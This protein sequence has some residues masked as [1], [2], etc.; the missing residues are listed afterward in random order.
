MVQFVFAPFRLLCICVVDRS[1]VALIPF[2]RRTIGKANSTSQT[3]VHLY[4]RANIHQKTL[5][6][7][8]T[9][10]ADVSIYAGQLNIIVASK[11]QSSI[12]SVPLR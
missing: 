5:L 4:I 8:V 11:P 2:C 12:L 7:T 3:L 6:T 10:E 1:V 9:M